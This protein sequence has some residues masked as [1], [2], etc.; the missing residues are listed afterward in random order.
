M[1]Q[2]ENAVNIELYFGRRVKIYK[3]S[4]F[5]GLL[6]LRTSPIPGID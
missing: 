4:N 2:N 5:L 1:R 6:E 3:Q